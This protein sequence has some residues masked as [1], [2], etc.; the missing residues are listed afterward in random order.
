MDIH[1]TNEQFK[2]GCFDGITTEEFIFD[3][4]TGDESREK[5]LGK[6]KITVNTDNAEKKISS[7]DIKVSQCLSPMREKL[8]IIALE[9]KI[10]FLENNLKEL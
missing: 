4:A 2:V 5:I 9:K 1:L 6:I 7:I 10:E 3:A 8:T